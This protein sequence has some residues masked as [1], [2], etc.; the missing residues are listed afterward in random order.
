MTFD[1]STMKLI[2]EN[3][4]YAIYISSKI[5]NNKFKGIR[6]DKKTKKQVEVII[7]KYPKKEIKDFAYRVVDFVKSK[8]K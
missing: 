4:L 5:N 6:V 7:E 1:L 3:E 2:M 8:E